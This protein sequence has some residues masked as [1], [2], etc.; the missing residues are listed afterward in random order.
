M[1]I[2]ISGQA[3][4]HPSRSV[5]YQRSV[6]LFPAKSGIME[7]QGAQLVEKKIQM[8]T[9]GLTSI[10]DL[11]GSKVRAIM[12]FNSVW[13]VIVD[14]TVYKVTPA[15]DGLSF[16]SSS[17]GTITGSSTGRI[18]W[19]RNPTQIMFGDGSSIGYTITASTDTLTQISDAQFTGLEFVVFVDS[20][21]IYNTPDGTTMYATA[22]NDGTS[23]DALDV[24]TAE[25]NPDKLKALIDNKREV[26][27]LGE[28]S[29][30][31]YY[32]AANAVG[33]P[34][35]TRDGAAV[36]QGI[37]AP[38]SLCKADNTLV[39]LD[40]RRF[41]VQVKGYGINVVSN[42]AISAEF[43]TYAKVDDAFAFS[44]KDRGHVFYQISFP[45]EQKTWVYDLT[46]NL[47]HERSYRNP[48][49]DQEEAHLANCHVDFN[50]R[51]YVGA[52]DSGKIYLMS[53]DYYQDNGDPIVRIRS[54]EHNTQELKQYSFNQLEL[55]ADMGRGPVDGTDP[56][57]I[58]RYSNDGGY[59][60]SHSMA[61]SL[62]DIGQYSN[63]AIWN[64][65]GSGKQWIFEFTMSENAPVALIDLFAEIDGDGNG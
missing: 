56:N 50:G 35:S 65:L 30:E 27:A 36:D 18:S 4:E 10:G 33:H 15:A 22:S 43:Q 61:R 24:L 6:N 62:G 12:P 63:R 31:V 8:H 14:Q 11:T 2:Q 41:V 48:T 51:S 1:K 38:H 23:V 39:W 54:T 40:D 55:H 20:Y 28:R 57:I 9:S 7:G 64:R 29:T 42:H 45:T 58:M 19:A 16:T 52:R 26:W 37:S 46:T 25:Y 21:F 60:W 3:Y 53:P 5:N 17:L 49:T 59:T 13:Y 34:F 47:W 32:N 44:F